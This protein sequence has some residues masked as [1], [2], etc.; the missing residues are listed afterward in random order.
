MVSMAWSPRW[1]GLSSVQG[2][3]VDKVA[4]VGQVSL[5]AL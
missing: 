3:V 5:G 2:F 1:P 4:L